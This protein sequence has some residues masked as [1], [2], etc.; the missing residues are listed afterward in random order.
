MIHVRHRVVRQ[1][2]ALFTERPVG[3][4]EIDERQARAQLREAV[5]AR[6]ALEL[7]AEHILVKGDHPV[8]VGHAYY[9]VINVGDVD[10]VGFVHLHYLT[11]IAIGRIGAA[12]APRSFSEPPMNA[13][14]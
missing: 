4:D 3:V 9:H 6:A 13:N 7:A 11:G 12:S 8:H 2:A 14:S 10:W 5:V 1:R